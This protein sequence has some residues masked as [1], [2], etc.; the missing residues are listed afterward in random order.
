MRRILC[1]GD[2]NTWGYIPGT[3]ERYPADVRWTGVVQ[4]I[5]G[6][7]YAIIE[8]GLNGR[9]SVYHHPRDIGR[10]GRDYLP[11][12]LISQKPLDL[13]VLMLGTNDLQWSDAY[14]AAEG[15]RT[16]IK[17]IRLL[18]HLDDGIP[19]FV[20]K[21]NILLLSP[22]EVHPIIDEKDPIKRRR[23]YV[24]ESHLFSQ[25]YEKVAIEMKCEFLDA[26]KYAQPSE[27][28]GLHMSAMCHRALGEA[29]AQRIKSFF[30]DA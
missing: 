18:N 19:I 26:A 22:I 20:D 5:L 2:S 24:Q 10:R 16:L 9:T 13:I 29:V 21:P 1:F 8:E 27:I 23:C 3:A 11:A 12:C 17:D 7:E 15:I 4:Q 28:D 25:A 6:R 30:A 14:G